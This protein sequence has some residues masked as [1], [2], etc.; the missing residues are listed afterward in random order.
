LKG[1]GIKGEGLVNGNKGKEELM[2]E[3]EPSHSFIIKLATDKEMHEM[4]LLTEENLSR[5]GMKPND[6]VSVSAKFAVPGYPYEELGVA[7]PAHPCAGS[8]CAIFR[9]PYGDE[10]SI[11][12]ISFYDSN[13]KGRHAGG[14][15]HWNN[16][17][18]FTKNGVPISVT[19]KV[20]RLRPITGGNSI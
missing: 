13:P 3:L 19:K 18:R 2:A 12:F 10:C 17:I 8:A 5:F 11:D 6:I 4:E 9:H 1:R 7:S 14:Q 15:P 20:I 16:E